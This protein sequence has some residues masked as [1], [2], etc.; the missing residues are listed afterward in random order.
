MTAT[1]THNICGA[2]VCCGSQYTSSHCTAS[3]V[4]SKSLCPV[5]V[6]ARLPAAQ[7]MP[8]VPCRRGASGRD[9]PE[10]CCG[11]SRAKRPAAAGT[12]VQQQL[13]AP[14]AAAVRPGRAQQ[15]T[16][17]ATCS[18]PG[19]AT[20]GHAAVGSPA[21]E[22]AAGLRQAQG[23]AAA[24]QLVSTPDRAAGGSAA[25]AVTATD[26]PG[27]RGMGS[28]PAA[29][30]LPD[31]GLPAAQHD[32]AREGCRPAGASSS[33]GGGNERHVLGGPGHSCQRS[34]SA[35]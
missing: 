29:A 22:W 7:L 11:R 16:R 5:L 34:R 26:R 19:R 15:P 25:Q 10:P 18:R 21:H 20:G 33:T 27:V 2:L 31:T 14:A 3:A 35:G 6:R 12:A 28:M 32:Q 30:C 13:P 9:E 4:S 23:C 17:Q 24:Q 1:R 8:G